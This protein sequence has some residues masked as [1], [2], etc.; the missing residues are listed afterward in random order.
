MQ[1]YAPIEIIYEVLSS[2]PPE[3]PL[4]ED[5]KSS[6]S[7]H[8]RTAKRVPSNKTFV[9]EIFPVQTLTL[10]PVCSF[11][12]ML[13]QPLTPLIRQHIKGGTRL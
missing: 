1:E 6:S 12:S 11:W 5:L 2:I 7:K 13:A 4:D 8:G 10:H 9:S 3:R